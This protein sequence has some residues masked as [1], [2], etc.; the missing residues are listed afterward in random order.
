M[1]LTIAGSL[2]YKTSLAW[3]SAGEAVSTTLTIPDKHI[4]I[5]SL[6]SAILT[7]GITRVTQTG[8][9]T[10]SPSMD[11]AAFHIAAGDTSAPFAT[12]GVQAGVRIMRI[13]SDFYTGTIDDV[14]LPGMTPYGFSTGSGFVDGSYTPTLAMATPGTITFESVW[15]DV[16]GD[17]SYSHDVGPDLYYHLHECSRNLIVSPSIYGVSGF[18]HIQIFNTGL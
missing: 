9:P 14:V 10:E 17:S 12:I 15:S 11:Y 18:K 7:D 4:A 8:F 2:Q 16:L 3:S 5:V 1:S 6:V 13:G